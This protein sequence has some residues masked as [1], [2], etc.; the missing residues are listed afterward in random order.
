LT[1]S[2][3][4]VTLVPTSKLKITGIIIVPDSSLQCFR[5]FLRSLRSRIRLVGLGPRK[6][7]SLK[8]SNCQLRLSF[9]LSSCDVHLYASVR[10]IVQCSGAERSQSI[11]RFSLWPWY[12]H[13]WSFEQHGNAYCR[14]ICMSDFRRLR[15][16]LNMLIQIS[17]LGGGGMLTTAQLISFLIGHQ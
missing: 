11:G 9:Q 4:A 10:S 5:R 1:D 3:F 14:K 2:Y 15:M 6:F 13:V 16:H 12:S 8:L 17:G 7:K